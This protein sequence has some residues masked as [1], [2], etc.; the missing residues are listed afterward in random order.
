MHAIINQHEYEFADGLTVLQAL[1]SVHLNVPTLCHDER[2]QPCGECRMCL[3]E[4]TQHGQTRFATACH[5]PLADGMQF[6]THT[7]A[8]EDERRSLLAMLAGRYQT[9]VVNRF[10][11]K[12]LHQL[13]RQYDLL[14]ACYGAADE[15]LRDVS[16]P[17]IAVDMARCIDCYRCVRIC[18]EVQGQ[19]VWEIL[20]RGA[21]TR[22]APSNKNGMAAN[23]LRHQQ[24]RLLRPR[25]PR[26][27][28]RRD[29]TYARHRRGDEFIRRHRTRAYD[30]APAYNR[31][32]AAPVQRRHDDD[33]H[34]KRGAASD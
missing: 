33:A 9:E 7:A 2:L 23:L 14:E 24:R 29:E 11:A 13:F 31:T 27:D 15:S 16:H 21:E 32:H 22:I 8:L 28:R 18:D 4:I 19:F 6:A 20:N 1:R 17:Y 34:E 10:Q 25:L 30:F 12:P 3:V 26:A 5:T